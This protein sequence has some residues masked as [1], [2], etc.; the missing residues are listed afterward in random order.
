MIT[1]LTFHRMPEDKAMHRSDTLRELPTRVPSDEFVEM[2]KAPGGFF[3]MLF[4]S[5]IGG[6]LIWALVVLLLS[7]G[8]S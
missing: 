3:V 2:Q 4:W 5:V 7:L 1:H 6:A 8:K